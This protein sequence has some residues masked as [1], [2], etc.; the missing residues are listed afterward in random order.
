[1][2]I[3]TNHVWEDSPNKK[4][5]SEITEDNKLQTTQIDLQKENTDEH[6][7]PWQH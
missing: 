3:K 5:K 6:F 2:K 4:V 1:M 7:W